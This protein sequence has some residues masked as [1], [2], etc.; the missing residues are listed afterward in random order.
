MVTWMEIGTKGFLST[1]PGS[2]PMEGMM[3]AGTGERERHHR[4]GLSQAKG[5]PHGKAG[6]AGLPQMNGVNFLTW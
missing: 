6:L 5:E 1:A 3:E 2:A 4:D